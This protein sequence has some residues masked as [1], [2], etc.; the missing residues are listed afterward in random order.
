VD[1]GAGLGRYTASYVFDGPGQTL[2]I[3]RE[4]TLRANPS[5]CDPQQQEQ[6]AKL[7]ATV[8]QDLASQLS[9]QM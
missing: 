3:K 6:L 8:R 1:V 9:V 2:H 4:V 5:E 7:A